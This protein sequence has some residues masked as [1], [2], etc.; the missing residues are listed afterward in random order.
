MEFHHWEES[1]PRNSPTLHIFHSPGCSEV[2]K[3]PK[4]SPHPYPGNPLDWDL[5]LLAPEILLILQEWRLRLLIWGGK[6]QWEKSGKNSGKIRGNPGMSQLRQAQSS[7]RIL[8]IKN[9]RI[10]C[11]ERKYRRGFSWKTGIV[12]GTGKNKSVNSGYPRGKRGAL[13]KG[14]SRGEIPG[15]ECEEGRRN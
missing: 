4:Y 6:K 7:E 12:V 13:G 1:N 8:G 10:D 9:S 3:I 15:W 5:T 2:A 14:D 11:G